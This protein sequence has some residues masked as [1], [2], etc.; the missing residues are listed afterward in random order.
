ME[1]ESS[2][3]QGGISK[4]D[5]N[6]TD[7]SYWDSQYTT[8]PRKKLKSQFWVGAR[9][10]YNLLNRFITP[11]SKVL[12]IGCA[13][14]KTLAWAVKIKKAKVTG[15]DYSETGIGVSRWLFEQMKLEGDF[16]YEDI[17][18]TSLPAGTFDLVISN[19]FIEHFDDPTEI[20][21]AHINLVRPGGVALITIPNY[22]GIYGDLQQF[23]APDNLR[24]HNLRIMNIDELKQLALKNDGIGKVEAYPWGRTHPFLVQFSNKIN[25]KVAWAFSLMWNC[26]GWLQP[27]NI[28]SLAPLLV[29]EIH[30]SNATLDA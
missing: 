5:N 6:K 11:G 18:H 20:V 25:H 4:M 22:G 21:K 14:G 3:D 17:F 2:L 26:I 30:R 28:P 16:L 23:F 8:L 15:V 12:E 10:Y 9:D 27:V 29:L 19:G 24:I 7:R 1:K 13:P